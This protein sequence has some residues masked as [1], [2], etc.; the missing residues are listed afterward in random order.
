MLV[1]L[2]N[3]LASRSNADVDMMVPNRIAQAVIDSPNCQL[4]AWS[5]MAN[6]TMKYPK[7]STTGVS[8]SQSTKNG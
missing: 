5:A 2:R 8:N 7:I 4:M 1:Y 6:A 3:A